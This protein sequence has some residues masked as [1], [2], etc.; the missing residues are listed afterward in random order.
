MNDSAKPD[1][2]VRIFQNLIDGR[3]RPALSGKWLDSIDPATGRVWARI[4][5]G[6]AADVDEAVA[7]A[8]RAFHGPWR[9]LS[10]AK[11]AGLL[12]RVAQ[13]VAEHA[14]EIAEIETR[15]NG[16]IIA[17]TTAGDL[18]AV[19][20]MLHYWAGAADKI[21][22]ETVS[23][24]PLSLNYILREPVGVIGIIVPWNSPVA[25]F[26]AKVGAAL[27][28]GNTVVVK[29]PETAS[30]STI[31]MAALFE[32]AG[33]PP[34]VVNV[35]AGLGSV[36]GDAIAGHRDV[37][38]ISFTGSTLT[39][40]A[41]TRR[42][43]DAI[44]P[45]SFEL[46]G[47]SANIIFADAD[48]NAAAVGATT[49]SIFTGGAGQVCIAGSRVLVQR[50]IYAEMVERMA[51]IAAKVRVGDPMDKATQMGPLA[52]DKQFD[53]VRDYIRVGRAE[54]AEVAYGGGSGGA[55]VNG[56]LANGYFVQ[57]TIFT[58][59][60]N[61]MRICREEIFGPVVC[62]LPFDDEEEAL[63]IAND[64]EYGL[65]CGIWTNQLKRAHRMAARVEV[66][67][68]WVNAYRRLHWAVP[69]GGVKDSGY[70]RDSG[71]ESLRGYQHTKAVWIDLA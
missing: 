1:A 2:P 61:K 55:A 66:G 28:A 27:A 65:A 10:A 59:V 15:D 14:A 49:M 41:I 5:A 69:F 67:C 63:A 19:V 42:S 45:L 7:A 22:G 17:E 32:K 68:V 18:P 47:K 62:V 44:K 60:N 43:A 57:P 31:A 50:P 3:S 23:V 39:A 36:A 33:F 52:F 26:A 54:G 4:P 24:S 70:G 25:I 53:K 35:V 20:E 58:G 6:D 48:V 34:G 12:R 16:R 37:G 30:G 9:D 51:A 71:M 56:D 40:R 13:I 29:P 21:H 11:R 46:G 64:S 38:K 8:K